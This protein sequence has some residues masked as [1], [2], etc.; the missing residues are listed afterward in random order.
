[1]ARYSIK[2]RGKVKVGIGIS[3]PQRMVDDLRAEADSKNIPVSK[4]IE[5]SLEERRKI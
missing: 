3:L 1:M 2:D 4:I 5:R